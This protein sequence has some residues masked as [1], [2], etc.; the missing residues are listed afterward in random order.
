M[1]TQPRVSG[2]GLASF[3]VQAGFVVTV[4]A[5]WFFASE[6]QVISPLALPH[7]GAVWREFTKLLAS[8]DFLPDLMLTLSEVAIAFT[9][10]AIAGLLLG[11][12]IAR[13]PALVRIFEPLLSSLNSIPAVMFVPLFVLLFGLGM[14]SKVVMGLL[15]GFFP[16]VLNTIAGFSNIEPIYLKAARSMGASQSQLFRRVLLP[17][18]LP[19]ILTGLRMGFIVAFLSILGAE[20]IG[21]Y[22][23][24]GHRIV[25]N[26]ETLAIPRMFAFIAFAIIVAAMINLLLNALERS[27]RWQ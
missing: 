8:G 12:A 6:L 1:R 27:G 25:E 16:V 26:A 15:T 21:S 17:S 14:S 2:T 7:P 18:A 3:A 20:A 9:A 5:F 4:F 23:G 13:S 22:A 11:Y 10:A 24:L 19:V